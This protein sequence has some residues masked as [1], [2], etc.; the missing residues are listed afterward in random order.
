VNAR[1]RAAILLAAPVL[2]LGA[3]GCIGGDDEA[4][5]IQPS[6][7][8]PGAVESVPAETATEPTGP[9]T[10]TTPGGGTGGAGK[11]DSPTNDTP[12][13]PGSPEEQ[14]ER[15]CDQNPGACG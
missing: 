4:D 7:S 13:K 8:E 9:S 2:A 10:T 14:F 3:A 12:P 11:P 15:F 6:I 1:G 5:D